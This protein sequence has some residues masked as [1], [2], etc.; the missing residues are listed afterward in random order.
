MAKKFLTDL[1]LAKNELRNGRIQNLASAP[2]SPVAGQIYYDTTLHQFGVYNGNTT[3]WD[4]MG[5]GSVTGPSS[6][7]DG[8]IALFNST[9]GKLIKRATTSGV[10]KAASGVIA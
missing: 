6:S 8:E 7:V 2:S 4:Y 9:T 10:L 3:S 5:T 1:D